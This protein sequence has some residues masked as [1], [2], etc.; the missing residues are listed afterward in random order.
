VPAPRRPSRSGTDPDPGLDT[1]ALSVPAELLGR[2]PGRPSG[3]AQSAPPATGQGGPPPEGGVT[4]GWPC[5]ACGATSPLTADVCGACGSAFLAGARTADVPL[6][7][8]PVI[9][10]I[11]RLQRG[12]RLGLAF[13]VVLAVVVL[14]ALLGLL[15]S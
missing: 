6:L 2:P 5:S 4:A 14:T 11:S 13:A 1:D 15:L 9:G 10:D 12:Q 7:E 8:L 3:P